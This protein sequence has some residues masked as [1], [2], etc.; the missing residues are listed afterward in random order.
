[1]SNLHYKME[2]VQTFDVP[3]ASFNEE[4]GIFT[5]VKGQ[6]LMS[7][8]CMSQKFMDQPVKPNIITNVNPIEITCVTITGKQIKMTVDRHNTVLQLKKNIYK[9]TDI[10]LD[11]QRIVFGG[12]QLEDNN[13][14]DTYNIENGDKVHLVVRLRGGMFHNTSG[15]ADFVSLNFNTKFQKGSKMIYELRKYVIHLDTLAE[16][17]RHLEK[18]ETDTQIDKIYKLIEDVYIL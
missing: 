5:D 15:R 4:M 9:K 2:T 13:T 12:K 18:C 3:I 8:Y 16:L 10:M 17:H 11:D 1:M 14:L 7:K 6:H